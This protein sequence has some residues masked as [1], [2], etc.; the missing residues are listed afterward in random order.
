MTYSLRQLLETKPDGIVIPML[1][2]DYAQ[3]RATAAEIR[4]TFLD[5]LLQATLV[6]DDEYVEPLNLDFVYGSHEDRGTGPLLPLD[7]QQRLTTLFLLHWYLALRDDALEDFSSYA[8]KG[9]QSRFGYRVRPSA[10][11]FFDRLVREDVS[12]LQRAI[13][14]DGTGSSLSGAVQNQS[15]FFLSWKRD[16][17]VR[18]ALVMLDAIHQRFGD[19]AGLYARISSPDKPRITFQFLD[20]DKLALSDDL[21]IKM[22]ARGKGLTAYENFKAQLEDYIKGLGLDE[23]RQIRGEIYSM[24]QYVALKLDGDWCDLFWDHHKRAKGSIFDQMASNALRAVALAAYPFDDTTGR[25][26]KEIGIVLAKLADDKLDTFAAYV[27][28]GAVSPAYVRALVALL[29]RFTE[30]GGRPRTFLPRTAYY[31]ERE[32]LESVLIGSQ[33]KTKPPTRPAWVQFV[34]YCAYLLSGEPLEGLDEW[35]RVLTNLAK[36]NQY[37]REQFRTTLVGVRQLLGRGGDQLLDHLATA[38][39][40]RTGFSRLQ[41]REERVKAQLLLRDPR[42]C[43]LIERAERHPYFQGQIEFLLEFSGVLDHVDDGQ[44]EPLSDE[45]DAS[46]RQSFERWLVRAEAVFS[47][48]DGGVLDLP[49]HLWERA[50]LTQGDYL[51]GYNERWSLLA[52]THDRGYTWRRLLRSGLNKDG[53]RDTELDGRRGIVGRILG[54]VDPQRVRRSLE[55]IVVDWLGRLEPAVEPWR[56][57]LVEYPE[58]IS[59]CQRRELRWLSHDRIYLVS[60]SQLNSK[61][62]EIHTWALERRLHARVEAGEFAPFDQCRP[63]KPSTTAVEPQMVLKSST[64]PG[65]SCRVSYRDGKFSLEVPRPLHPAPPD[66]PEEDLPDWS[67]PEDEIE[68]TL[69]Q[70]AARC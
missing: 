50:L 55:D 66:D 37:D 6:S 47:G 52:N 25:E 33:C 22:N 23:I 5:A 19:H 11:D 51:L 32:A 12:E 3:G 41:M 70:L 67:V 40:L 53:T 58:F 45:D 63:T 14:S 17:T 56:R 2:R 31:D 46:L 8:R 27:D 34:A 9:N 43:S 16:P 68:A 59:F 49:D 28:A 10:K 44:L 26:H 64:R 4:G 38:D 21:Y 62:R 48:K 15:W 29:D 61:H 30:D 13:S 65:L 54:R 36:N 7:G 42:W 20:L 69:L 18:S 35:M 1:Q 57:A 24:D 60:K 39:T